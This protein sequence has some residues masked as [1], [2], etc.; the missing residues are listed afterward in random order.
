M[1]VWNLW[2]N[3]FGLGVLEITG[4]SGC[5]GNWTF[6]T[7]LFVQSTQGIVDNQSGSGTRFNPTAGSLF[8]A[9]PPPLPDYWFFS[10]GT[11]DLI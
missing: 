10:C 3:W 9:A 5:C 4:A 8:S 2:W 6:N 7:T 11:T 1:S